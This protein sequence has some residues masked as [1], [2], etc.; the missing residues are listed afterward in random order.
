ME[1][2]LVNILVIELQCMYLTN[3]SL[4]HEVIISVYINRQFHRL[5]RVCSQSVRLTVVS[6]S[7]YSDDFVE[8]GVFGD[9]RGSVIHMQRSMHP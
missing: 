6:C 8:V 4:L 7:S 2:M 5:N 9:F 1:V 3:E